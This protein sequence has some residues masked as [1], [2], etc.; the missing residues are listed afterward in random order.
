VGFQFCIPKSRTNA[1]RGNVGGK[2][3]KRN[4]RENTI[5]A[6]LTSLAEKHNLH[7]SKMT[8][9]IKL[10]SVENKNTIYNLP[11]A[12]GSNRVTGTGVEIV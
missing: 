1:K 12:L 4:D 5:Y 11:F 3:E 2:L 6:V 7:L 9:T 8:S 10:K